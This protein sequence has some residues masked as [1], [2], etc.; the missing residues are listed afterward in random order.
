[1]IR[2][3]RILRED[4]RIFRLDNLFVGRNTYEG[5]YTGVL[6]VPP[7]LFN[8]YFHDALRVWKSMFK[9][10]IKSLDTAR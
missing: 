10:G 1:M 2:A 8:I 3:I 6:Y 7:T 9:Q 4:D 5:G